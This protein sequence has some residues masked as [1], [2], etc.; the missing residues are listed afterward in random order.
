M[1]TDR[2]LAKIASSCEIALKSACQIVVEYKSLKAHAQTQDKIKKNL[3]KAFD[4]EVCRLKAIISSSGI[5]D[6]NPGNWDSDT[7]KDRSDASSTE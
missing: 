1:L 2:E 6:P 7:Y 5:K 3:I 4:E